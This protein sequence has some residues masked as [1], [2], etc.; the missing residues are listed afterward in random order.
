MRLPSNEG[1]KDGYQPLEIVILPLLAR[2]AY[3]RL[4]IDTDLLFQLRQDNN[5]MTNKF[6]GQIQHTQKNFSQNKN[7]GGAVA[8]TLLPVNVALN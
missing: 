5:V 8:T 6:K 3:K 7:V 2:L 4:Q 1:I